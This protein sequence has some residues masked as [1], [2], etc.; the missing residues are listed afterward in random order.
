M[1]LLIWSCL[2]FSLCLFVFYLSIC[3]IS[4][5]VFFWLSWIFFVLLFCD[6]FWILAIACYFSNLKLL[7]VLK[8][9]IYGSMPSGYIIPLYLWKLKVLVTQSCPTLCD[10]MNCSPP[11]SSVHGILQARI[12][13]WVNIPFSRGSSWPGKQTRVS[14][15]AGE[16]FIIWATREAFYL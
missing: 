2:R 4:F 5:S 6:F 15:I 14:C 8:Y 9:I 7:E 1:W 11:G 16:F 3:Y 12:L 10:C 13:E